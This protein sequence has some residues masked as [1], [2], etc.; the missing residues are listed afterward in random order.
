MEENKSV[1]L[2]QLEGCVKINTEG[3]IDC[4]G[5]KKK[6]SISRTASRHK[7]VIPKIEINDELKLGLDAFRRF[8]MHFRQQ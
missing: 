4:D 5:Q 6:P 2:S 1:D 7:F 8:Q 3:R